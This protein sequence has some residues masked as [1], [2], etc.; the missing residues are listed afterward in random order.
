MIYIGNVIMKLTINIDDP[1]TEMC[2]KLLIGLSRYH[3]TVFP[4]IILLLSSFNN[5][6]LEA[7]LLIYSTSIFINS[8]KI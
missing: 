4:F 1:S 2:V 8:R 5:L 7:P 3:T 6:Y